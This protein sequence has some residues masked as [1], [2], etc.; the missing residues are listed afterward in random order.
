[1]KV[2]P[3]LNSR[4][5]ELSSRC[6]LLLQ[7]MTIDSQGSTFVQVKALQHQESEFV[8][9]MNNCEMRTLQY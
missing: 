4:P 8:N 3:S 2:H 1:M 6:V 7:T 5:V 9:A